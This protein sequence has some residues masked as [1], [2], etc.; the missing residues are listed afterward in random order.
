MEQRFDNLDE[1]LREV[2]NEER[3]QDQRRAEENR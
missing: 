2:Q 1:Y 3:R